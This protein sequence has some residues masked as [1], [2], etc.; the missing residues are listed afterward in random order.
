MLLVCTFSL[1][2][3]LFRTRLPFWPAR[4]AR[5]L[6]PPPRRAPLAEHAWEEHVLCNL[7]ASE[8]VSE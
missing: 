7:T 4:P 5:Q 2:M 8:W 6:S 3:D 1:P